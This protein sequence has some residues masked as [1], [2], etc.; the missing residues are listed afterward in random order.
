[1]TSEM[2]KELHD[3]IINGIGKITDR[4]VLVASLVT[5]FFE[6]RVLQDESEPEYA[7]SRKEVPDR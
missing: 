3:Y 6:E 1:M 7:T 4:D 5:K 2:T